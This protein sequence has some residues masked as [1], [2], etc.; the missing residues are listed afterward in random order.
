MLEKKETN[1]LKDVAETGVKEYNRNCEYVFLPCCGAF[2]DETVSRISTN[3]V[4]LL[5]EIG[6]DFGIIK[7]HKTCCGDIAKNTGNKRLLLRLASKNISLF[8]N[9]DVQ[10]IIAGSPHCYN[11]FKNDYPEFKGSYEVYHITQIINTAIAQEKL[12]ISGDKKIK[13]TFQDPCHLGK[14]N[15]EYLAPRNI[16]K[17]LPGA[18]LIEM[19][20][21]K[22]SSLCCGGGGGG[23]W[24][25]NEKLKNLSD[26]RVL[27][28]LATGAQ[29]LVTSCPFCS[30]MFEKSIIENDLYS[31]I[32][33]KDVCEVLYENLK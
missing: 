11:I 33:S 28:A 23:V 31:K 8:N 30:I 18:E 19:Q 10:K 5:K 24:L 20:K 1:W 22:E 21:S 6:I 12:K 15:Q 9:K 16:I 32:K 4:K 17:S 13:L 25:R 27:D 14:Y 7:E 2:F 26:S 3:Q 29:V